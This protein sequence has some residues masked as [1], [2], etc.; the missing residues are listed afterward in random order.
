VSQG[1][2]PPPHEVRVAE[3]LGGR[4][5]QA[6]GVPIG[7]LAPLEA[8]ARAYLEMGFAYVAV[9]SDIVVLRRGCDA[10]GEMFKSVMP[11]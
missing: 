8:D 11:T 10:L 7:T 5:A 2:S 9:G 4:R 3:D 1:V 6:A